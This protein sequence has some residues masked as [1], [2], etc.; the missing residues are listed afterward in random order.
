MRTFKSIGVFCGSAAGES[1]EHARAA[2]ELGAELAR[3]EI[4]LV[5]GGGHI[6]LMGIVADAALAGGGQVIGVMPEQLVRREIAHRGLTELRVV[7]SMHERK[8]TMADL[9]DAFIMLSGGFGS[10]D[11]FCEVVTWAQL[12]IHTNP[13]GILNVGGYYDPLVAMMDRAV[14]EGFVRPRNRE[15]LAV[16]SDVNAL[17]ARLAATN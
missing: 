12:G 15:M 6:G 3:R 7:K 8:Q 5:Y 4:R 9:S 14:H 11:E 17:L 16:E 2:K 10:W 1:P 13:C